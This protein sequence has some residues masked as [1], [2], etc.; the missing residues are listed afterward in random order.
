MLRRMATGLFLVA[1][2]AASCSQKSTFGFTLPDG[3]VAAGKAAFV[4]LGCSSCHRVFA[5]DDLPEPTAKPPV[6]TLGG[7]FELAPNDGR[8]LMAIIDPS[9][10]IAKAYPGQEH[11]YPG[12]EKSRMHDFTEVMTIRDLID[13]VA[14][15]HTRYRPASAS[16]L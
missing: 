8:L 12:S 7:A 3:D 6:K 1:L 13:V 4:R 11:T 5:A 10:K 14:F 16:N 9:D 15:L 2:A